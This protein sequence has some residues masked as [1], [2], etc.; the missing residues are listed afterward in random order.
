MDVMVAL[1]ISLHEMKVRS[2]T[3]ITGLPATIFQRTALALASVLLVSHLGPNLAQILRIGVFAS[4]PVV[5]LT[6]LLVLG[7][8]TISTC[9]LATLQA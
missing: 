7:P 2:L 4:L 9:L 5:D 3:E 8:I 1:T 6:E